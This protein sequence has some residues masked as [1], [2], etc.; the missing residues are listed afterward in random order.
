MRT[1]LVYGA[2]EGGGRRADQCIDTCTHA[3]TH[4]LDGVSPVVV[5][6][7][8]VHEVVHEGAHE[9]P[10]VREEQHAPAVALVREPGGDRVYVLC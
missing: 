8:P 5:A 9:E 7:R 10:A 4:L 3:Y 6:A 2:A 1:L